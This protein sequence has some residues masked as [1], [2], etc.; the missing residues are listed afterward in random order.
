MNTINNIKVIYKGVIKND[1]RSFTLNNIYLARVVRQG[2]LL[3]LNDDG[4]LVE[5]DS[6]YFEFVKDHVLIAV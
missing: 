5:M 4:I 2:V 3:V 1:A 6:I